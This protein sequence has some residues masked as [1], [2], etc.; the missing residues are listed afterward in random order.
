MQN[1]ESVAQK[2]AV[3][4]KEDGHLLSSIYSQAIIQAKLVCVKF[5][6]LDNKRRQKR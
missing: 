5:T 1:L 6:S 2:M 3:G 4:T